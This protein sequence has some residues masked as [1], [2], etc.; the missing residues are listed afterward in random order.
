MERLERFGRRTGV[1]A[2]GFL[3]DV[4]VERRYPVAEPGQGNRQSSDN[5]YPPPHDFGNTLPSGTWRIAARPTE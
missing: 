5:R 3:V 1:Q 2:N 4:A